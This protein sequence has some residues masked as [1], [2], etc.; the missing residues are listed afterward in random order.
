MATFVAVPPDDIESQ[1]VA[2]RP[3]WRIAVLAAC[4]VLVALIAAALVLGRGPTERVA[5]TATGYFPPADAPT[6]FVTPEAAFAWWWDE[7]GGP[8]AAASWVGA[9]PPGATGAPPS[10]ERGSWAWKEGS[11]IWVVSDDGD[12]AVEV[13]LQLR[14][15]DADRW[16]IAGVNSCRR[17]PA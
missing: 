15:D 10:P 8:Q 3:P 12:T 17:Q 9:Q 4:V 13:H 5:C 11:W 7:G 14:Q 2:R 1:E 16:Q 6:T